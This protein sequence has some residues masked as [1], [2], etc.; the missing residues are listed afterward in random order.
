MG[1][2]KSATQKAI[3]YSPTS[4]TYSE[5]AAFLVKKGD[6]RGAVSDY[7]TS[8]NLATAKKQSAVFYYYKRG[9][10]YRFNLNEPA[11]ASADFQKVI[12]QDK[13]NSVYVPFSKAFTG[14]VDQ[15]LSM[16]EA[17]IAKAT[18]KQ[19]EY[20]NMACLHSLLGNESEAIRYLDLAFQNGYNNYEWFQED[21]DFNSVKYKPAFKNLIAKY[22]IPYD[23]TINSISEV[24][25]G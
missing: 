9:K 13:Y 15:A 12:E 5:R 7:T 2:Q 3:Q 11:L 25:K 21:P 19:G 17:R 8:I 4:Y 23:L 14:D 16:M 22:R 20:Y 18:E 6:Y 1:K 10:V 24:I